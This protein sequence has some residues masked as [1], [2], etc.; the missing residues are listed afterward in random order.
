MAILE[1]HYSQPRLPQVWQFS[2]HNEGRGG[3]SLAEAACQ[4]WQGVSCF[5]GIWFLLRLSFGCGRV[6]AALEMGLQE[7]VDRQGKSVRECW[8]G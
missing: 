8:A 7:Q 1:G 2:N 4:P 3:A 6:G 5:R